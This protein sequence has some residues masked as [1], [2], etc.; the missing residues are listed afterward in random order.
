MDAL[1]AGTYYVKIDEYGNNDEIATYDIAFTVVR[2]CGG[3]G[4]PHEANDTPGQATLITYGTT[5]SDPDL[6]PAG[7]A[8]YYA[9]TGSAGDT[10][11]A[12][13]DAQAIGSSLDSYLYLYDTDGI[14]ELAHNDDYDGLDSRVMYTLPA[15]GTYY[16][17]LREFSHPYLGGSDYFYSIS[18]GPPLLK[19]YLPTLLK[20]HR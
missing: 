5:F 15:D 8:D 7:D 6:C 4:D 3:C 18:L 16:L 17:M 12:D 13:V 20:D 2:A 14:T 9:F 19:T 1:P 11:V 10:I